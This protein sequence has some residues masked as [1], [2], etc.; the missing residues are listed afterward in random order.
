VAFGWWATRSNIV[1]GQHHA[2]DRMIARSPQER[3]EQIDRLSK[4][5]PIHIRVGERRDVGPCLELCRRARA[6]AFDS[7]LGYDERKAA[8]ILERTLD[9]TLNDLGLVAEHTESGR[10]VGFLY[11][12]GGEHMYAPVQVATCQM[13]Y[14]VPEMRWTIAPF[15]LL[16][17]W[18]RRATSGGAALA[19]VHVTSGIRIRETHRFLGKLYFTHVGGNYVLPLTAQMRQATAAQR[20]EI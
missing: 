12:T 14:V 9:P 15:A 18:I 1:A 3:A 5:S 17:S 2:G 7:A 19:S 4:E 10:V 11:G 8:I 13:I 6:E 16:R 20:Q